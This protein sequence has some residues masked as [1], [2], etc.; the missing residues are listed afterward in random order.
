MATPKK[1]LLNP[2]LASRIAFGKIIGLGIGVSIFF[3][4]PILQSDID[5]ALRY[6]MLGW[7]VIFGAVIAFVGIYTKYPIFNWPI[8]ALLRGAVIGFAMNLVLGCLIYQDMMAAFSHY[9]EFQFSNSMPIIQIA[10]E[11]LIWG[12]LIEF[13][14]TRYVGQGDKLLKNL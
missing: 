8:P 3:T 10:I 5:L 7:Y 12:T 4:L 6:G 11:G 14:L 9:T 1:H 13:V 2:S